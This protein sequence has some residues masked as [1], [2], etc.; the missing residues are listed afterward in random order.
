V[1]EIEPQSWTIK[2]GSEGSTDEY[3]PMACIQKQFVNDNE[4]IKE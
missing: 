2:T 3:Y 1:L 4:E